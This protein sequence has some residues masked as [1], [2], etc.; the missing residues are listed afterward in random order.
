MIIET[1]VTTINL[2]RSA[3]LSPMGAVFGERLD[4]FELRPYT[5]SR[6]LENL[7][8]RREGVVH[9]VDDALLLVRALLDQ[10]PE[11]PP[12]NLATV[13]AAPMLKEYLR[14]YEFRAKYIDETSHRAS[15]TC[16]I[17]EQHIGKPP[18][19]IC[20]G[21]NAV[22]EASILISRSEFLPAEE[23]NRHLP[24]LERIVAKT[25]NGSD[26]EAMALL[27]AHYHSSVARRTIEQ[28]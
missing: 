13:V 20:R 16:E 27:L 5:G 22:V 28:P 17:V 26:R 14:A 10:W 3:N 25:G 4:S 23:I 7:R 18:R 8:Q 19:G 12:L 15:I 24:D 9:V 2:D 21:L 11:R 1:I 6:T